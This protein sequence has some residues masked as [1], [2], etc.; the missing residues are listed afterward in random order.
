M[1][2]DLIVK[3]LLAT[4]ALAE[5][6]IQSIDMFQAL[7]QQEVPGAGIAAA[8]PPISPS[9][10]G[11]TDGCLHPLEHQLPTP[12]MGNMHRKMCGV[13]GKEIPREDV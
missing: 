12:T 8:P 11:V 3:Q 6:L 7:T 1:I 9:P 10:E 13:C 5:A 2:H 4:R